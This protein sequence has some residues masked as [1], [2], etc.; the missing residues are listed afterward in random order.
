MLMT[1]VLLVSVGRAATPPTAR[2]RAADPPVHL[3][4]SSNGNFEYGARAKAHVRAAQ[5]GYLVVV[6]ADGRVHVLFPLDPQGEQQVRGGKKYEL[7]GRGDREAFV[8][9]DTGGRG[10]V[11]AALSQTPFRFDEFTKDEHWDYGALSD[12]SVKADP[13]SGL[14][15]VV[16]RMQATGEHFD[17][18]VSIYTSAP[19]H[20]PSLDPYLSPYSSYPY[21][22][23]SFYPYSYYGP[24]WWDYG[25][26]GLG[27]WWGWG[28]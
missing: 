8:V 27:F 25:F 4:L 26:G 11:L 19:R 7:K 15:D 23:Y 6:H 17:Y 1:F 24:G 14:L 5:E 28:Y 16:Q 9:T 18:D 10:A 21:S 20:A 12:H 3:W 13:E 22:H 2:T